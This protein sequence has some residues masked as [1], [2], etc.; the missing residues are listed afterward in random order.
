MF[1]GMDQLLDFVTLSRVNVSSTRRVTTAQITGAGDPGDDSTA[2][3]VDACEV[4]QPLG[5]LAVPVLGTNTE[6]LIAR[7][8]DR[9]VV[10]AIVDK[11]RGAQDVEQGEARLYG[12][13]DTNH[14]AVV[15]IRATGKIEVTPKASQ[16]LVLN[17]GLLKAAR[18]TD[19]VRIGTITATAG[20]YPVTFTVTLVDADGV[21][22]TPAVGATATLTGVISNAG[23][24][25]NVKA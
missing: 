6:A 22:G 19:P 18:V 21:P 16:D 4:V 12:V 15:R 20:P 10:L 11:S 9:P 1:E 25:P 23:G 8:G 24:A 14:A 3:R 17:A 13:G 5:L 7:V 2:E